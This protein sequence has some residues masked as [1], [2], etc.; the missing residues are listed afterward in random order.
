ML[1]FPSVMRSAVVE[2]GGLNTH[3]LEITPGVQSIQHLES[4]IAS[5]TPS[6]QLLLTATEQYQL[7]VGTEKLF[8]LLHMLSWKI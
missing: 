1:T 7:E 6:K 8:F 3:S 2:I 4:L 5:A